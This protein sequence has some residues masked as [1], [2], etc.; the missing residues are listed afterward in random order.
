LRHKYSTK[1]TCVMNTVPYLL[2][3][4]VLYTEIRN[5]KPARGPCVLGSRRCC[6]WRTSPS[7]RPSRR[8]RRSCRSCSWRRATRRLSGFSLVGHVNPQLAHSF[9]KIF[10]NIFHITS[11]VSTVSVTSCVRCFPFKDMVN[12]KQ[13]LFLF[14]LL[15]KPFLLQ[16]AR[17]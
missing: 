1:F 3:G 2:N 5:Y 13:T 16:S 12:T 15:K 4:M 6:C 8:R 7:S 10:V 17:L 11:R 14:G 9:P